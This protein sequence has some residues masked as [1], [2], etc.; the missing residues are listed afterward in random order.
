MKQHNQKITI[1]KSKEKK[2]VGY[3]RKRKEAHNLAG[4]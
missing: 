1:T 2:N 4:L 3:E